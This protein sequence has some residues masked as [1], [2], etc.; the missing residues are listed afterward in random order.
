MSV[1]IFQWQSQLA[2]AKNAL[3]SGD[4][5]TAEEYLNAAMTFSHDE[6]APEDAVADIFYHRGICF[7]NKDRFVDARRAFNQAQHTFSRC[8]GATS[9]QALKAGKAKCFVDIKMGRTA[10]AQTEFAEIIE[11]LRCDPGDFAAEISSMEAEMRDM[12][13]H[14]ESP[15][16]PGTE[17]EIEEYAE[18]WTP[19]R[20]PP[21]HTHL[22]V[23]DDSH[24]P[25]SFDFSQKTSTHTPFAQ[26]PAS[27][28]APFGSE[29]SSYGSST[30]SNPQPDQSLH[31]SGN[32]ATSGHGSGNG[33]G[34]SQGLDQDRKLNIP[35]EVSDAI[36]HLSRSGQ[37]AAVPESYLTGGVTGRLTVDPSQL[38]PLII[39]GTDID[40][41]SREEAARKAEEEEHSQLAEEMA[42]QAQKEER[43]RLE[44]EQAARKA[45]EEEIRQAAVLALRLAEEEEAQ[46]IAE[47]EARLTAEAE[48]R[49]ADEEEQK[50]LA[51]EAA[52]ARIAEEEERARVAA[53]EAARKA[54][55]TARKEEEEK[56]RVAAEEA[57]RNAEEEEKA[58]LAADEAAK[59]TIEEKEKARIAAEEATRKAEEDAR[60]EA[61]EAAHKADEDAREAAAAAR[62]AAQEEATIASAEA[63]RKARE[64]KGRVHFDAD[65]E[66]KR[67]SALS[68][69]FEFDNSQ[70]LTSPSSSASASSSA[71]TSAAAS[72]ESWVPPPMSAAR[73]NVTQTGAETGAETNTSSG[74][75]PVAQNADAVSAQNGAQSEVQ[76][77]AQTAEPDVKVRIVRSQP[78][79]YA[80]KRPDGTMIDLAAFQPPAGPVVPPEPNLSIVKGQN[81]YPNERRKEPP[82]RPDGLPERRSSILAQVADELTGNI[83]GKIESKSIDT[84]AA[85]VAT[86]LA[87]QVSEVAHAA[88]HLTSPS[89]KTPDLQAR[90]HASKLA[91]ESSPFQSPNSPEA[92]AAA[93]AAKAASAIPAKP[94]PAVA[95]T[96]SSVAP[97]QHN[98]PKL[99]SFSSTASGAF[100]TLATSGA[101]AILPSSALTKPTST[102][103]PKAMPAP[104]AASTEPA[105]VSSTSTAPSKAPETSAPLATP[106]T[107]P[108]STPSAAAPAVPAAAAPVPA[109]A[110][111]AAAP[112]PAAAAPVPAAAAAAPAAAGAAAVA[113][114]ATPPTPPAAT[115]SPA[116]TAAESPATPSPFSLEAASEAP[117]KAAAKNKALSSAPLH[118]NTILD[119]PARTVNRTMMDMGA[120]EEDKF[121]FTPHESLLDASSGAN[122][123]GNSPAKSVDV[124]KL[125][126][127]Q[128][129]LS[130]S[131]N[132]SAP[133][134][135]AVS[136]FAPT[137]PSDNATQSE[138]GRTPFPDANEG[139]DKLDKNRVSGSRPG[140]VAG[141]PVSAQKSL[142]TP[143]HFI[144]PLN[145]PELTT[146]NERKYTQAATTAA[147]VIYGLS[148]ICLFGIVLV[149]L[150][151]FISHVL[152]GIRLGRMRGNGIKVTP[153]QFPEVFEAVHNLAASLGMQTAPETYVMNKPGLLNACAK[154]FHGRDYVIIYTDVLELAYS[155]G[156]SELAFVI[157]H[158]LAHI[159]CGH[160]KRKWLDFPAKLV[161]FLGQALS[162]ARE[163][164]C[165]KIAQELVPEGASVGLVALSVGTKLFRRINLKALY[166]QQDSVDDFW[167]SFSEAVSSTPNLNSRI[168]ALAPGEERNKTSKSTTAAS[169]KR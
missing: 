38:V 69:D 124:A 142:I 37:M 11:L 31:S 10:E 145:I 23:P 89:D 41:A 154:N 60:L 149:P 144:R 8:L 123:P 98:L 35:L 73:A 71:K 17:V 113:S 65:D 125:S 103:S 104:V 2:L 150:I 79:A 78:E 146:P 166:A 44:A 118:T 6:N 66:E 112:V 12:L 116:P 91:G 127:F 77:G 34:S 110:A 105:A 161:P 99:N 22:S 16:I 141:G 97:T 1:Q 19:V 46:L 158:E 122:T 61:E 70:A 5:L 93:S 59:K 167:S 131:A 95:P 164:T 136:P 32:G 107:A 138:R 155:F 14:P 101:H 152:D 157:A 163:Y 26:E 115:S 4:Y 147:V 159:Q 53:D 40:A 81:Q 162:R 45:E 75:Q 80:S 137:A 54:E 20:R 100:A 129:R 13:A 88:E 92:P 94:T 85:D 117:S 63:A 126:E 83:A 90:A 55:E 128:Q 27:Q 156:E 57:A 121:E 130:E 108:G 151:M 134:S 18:S 47:E 33:Q 7:E 56:A 153:E 50:R 132:V 52:K 68:T 143:R 102:S 160:L 74:S 86:S 111:A 42:L 82:L 114:T 49:K 133:S 62:K 9:S 140:R 96:T 148:V 30:G 64:G 169:K 168:R 120:A 109:A 28:P 36:A 139:D 43:A 48:A 87:A 106:L 58:R 25:S 21:D 165:D 67:I 15:D 24:V 119:M 51:E 39:P 72:R 76:A 29:S 3:I 84:I 135:A